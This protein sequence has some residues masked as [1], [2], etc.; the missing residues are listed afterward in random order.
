[1]ARSRTISHVAM[2][3]PEGTLTDDYRGRVLDF[4]GE[5]LGWRELVSFRLPDR[6]TIGV[7]PGC[8]VNVREQPGASA[9]DPYQHFGVCVRSEQELRDLWDDLDSGHPDVELQPISDSGSGQLTFR[10]QH[11]L[12]FAVE[13]QYFA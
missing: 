6:L 3:V 5:I 8:Y 9:R 10:F 2:S 11:L 1:M 13:V 7:G 12:P 4:Y